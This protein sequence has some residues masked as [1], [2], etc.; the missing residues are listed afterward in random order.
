MEKDKE[1]CV[2]C[3]KKLNIGSGNFTN[4]IPILDNYEERKANGRPYP[5]GGWICDKCDNKRDN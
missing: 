1:I 4:R 5:D 2:E 3:G